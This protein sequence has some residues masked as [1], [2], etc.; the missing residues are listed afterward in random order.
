M[1]QVIHKSNDAPL[2]PK[3]INGKYLKLVCVG[4]RCLYFNLQ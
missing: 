1:N 3:I 2:I 4:R